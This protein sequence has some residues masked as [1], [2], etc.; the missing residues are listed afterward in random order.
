MERILSSGPLV[1]CTEVHMSSLESRRILVTGGSRG[2]GLAMV[3][4]FVARKAKV[5]VLA[6]DRGR[7]DALAARLPVSVVA[8]DITDAALATRLVADLRPDV[9]VLN[10][11]ASP[12]VGPIHEASWEAFSEAWNSD[13]RGAFHWVQAA[14]KVPL[15]AGSRVLLGSSGAAV[16][17]SPLSGGYAG[18]K[19]MLWLMASYA[20][21]AAQRAGIDIKFQAILPRQIIPETDLGRAASEM[22]AQAKGISLEAFSAGFGTPMPPARFAEHVVE[23]L[24]DPKYAEGT[25]WGLKGDTGIQS[26]DA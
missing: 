22:Y 11:G 20:N 26:L 25:A 24:T 14:M 13:V 1:E 18:A 16:Q 6:R 10:A 15:P 23:I 2:L 12:A 19:R 5:T 7:L 4:A 17:G 3:E 8:G 21:L 9:L